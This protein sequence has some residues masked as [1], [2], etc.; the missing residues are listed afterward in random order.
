M[1][2]PGQVTVALWT[3]RQEAAEPKEYFPALHGDIKL[4]VVSEHAYPAGQ[5]VQLDCPPVLNVPELQAYLPEL[6]VVEGH[7]YPAAQEVHI[8]AP[9]DEYVPTAHSII[10]VEVVEGHIYPALHQVQVMAPPA[11]KNRRHMP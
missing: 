9:A 5:A 2:L 6:D 7:A 11:E 4:L 8:V 1:M 3:C 10:V